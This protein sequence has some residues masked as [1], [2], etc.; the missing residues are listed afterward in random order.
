[1]SSAAAA[2]PRLQIQVSLPI[3]L[4]NDHH[5]VF[6]DTPPSFDR[7]YHIKTPDGTLVTVHEHG[8]TAY[9]KGRAIRQQGIIRRIESAN[10]IQVRWLFQPRPRR[11][12]RPP[13]P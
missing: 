11:A 5:L 7:E 10:F 2:K 1:M 3:I 9:E 13:E 6:S 12:D 4:A 8:T